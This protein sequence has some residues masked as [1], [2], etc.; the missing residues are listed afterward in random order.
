MP[1]LESLL[2]RS[3]STIRRIRDAA[4]FAVSRKRLVAY[5][6]RGSRNFGDELNPV[7]M[8][9][10][11]GMHPT[12]VRDT[13]G[14]YRGPVFTAVGSVLQGVRAPNVVVWG[15]GFIAADST[16]LIPPSSIRAVRGP[17]TRSLILAQGLP[18]PEV[19]GDPALL[20]PRFFN[21]A[22]GTQDGVLGIVP[23]YVDKVNGNVAR[24]AAVDGVRIIDVQRDPTAVVSEICACAAIASSSLHGVI[25]ALA[26]GIPVVWVEFSDMVWGHRFKFHD[27]FASIRALVAEPVLVT[28]RTTRAELC[29]RATL[30]PLNI[31]LELLLAVCPFGPASGDLLDAATDWR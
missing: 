3:R 7:L 18:C 5:W 6:Y 9:H 19:F 14:R 12:H 20:Y 17:L 15:S 28:S 26:Y 24:L 21:P 23:H 22:P 8:K 11:A 13:F 29:G 30:W 10:I 25:I 31:D 4:R 27:F 2:F 16:F 1:R